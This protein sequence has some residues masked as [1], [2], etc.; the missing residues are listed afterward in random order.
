M[1]PIHSLAV[2]LLVLVVALGAAM[3]KE[4]SASSASNSNNNKASGGKTLGFYRHFGSTLN[5]N[6][7][8]G[9]ME[10]DYDH[11]EKAGFCPPMGDDHPFAQKEQPER[12][13]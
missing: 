8:A 10:C 6:K 5:R 11:P 1:K 7:I 9:A 2:F 13:Q 4:P 3:H 12:S